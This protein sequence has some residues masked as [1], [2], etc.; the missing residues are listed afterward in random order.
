M[1]YGWRWA[2]AGML[3][4]A[5]VLGAN[6]WLVATSRAWASDDLHVGHG[7]GGFPP[8]GGAR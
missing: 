7:H 1:S 8:Q 3:F 6:G 5:L 2:L 4:A